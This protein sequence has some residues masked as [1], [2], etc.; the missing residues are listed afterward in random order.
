MK[1]PSE[2]EHEQKCEAA[3]MDFWLKLAAVKDS[4]LIISRARTVLIE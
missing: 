3:E 4:T 2:H 1:N